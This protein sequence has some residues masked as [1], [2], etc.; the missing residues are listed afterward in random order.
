MFIAESEL[1]V[2]YAETDQMGYT[3]HSNYIIYYEFG[4]VEALRN[5]G[6]SY[7]DMELSGVMMPVIDCQ[8]RY[9]RPALYDDLIKI[10]VF[11]PH[12]PTAK[13]QFDYKLYVNNI[14]IND[15]YTTLAFVNTKTGKPIRVPQQMLTL[16]KPFF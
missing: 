3:H 2:R 13:I 14:L 4:R 8:L 9:L 5:L 16:L 1:R 10:K 7:K 11:I 15:G 6:M 12:L